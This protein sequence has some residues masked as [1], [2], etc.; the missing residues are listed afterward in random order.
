MLWAKIRGKQLG[1]LRFMRQ[2]SAG[3]YI[4][5]FYCPR[6]RLAIE[7]DGQQHKEEEIKKY[8]IER[9]RYLE[10]LKI[11]TIRFWN[12]EVMGDI[13]NVIVKISSALPLELK[14]ESE[15]V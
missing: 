10:S 13:E 1:G 7:L 9:E 15:G 2:Y 6:A 11:K 12:A 14:R 8:D 4:L 3:A 5:D